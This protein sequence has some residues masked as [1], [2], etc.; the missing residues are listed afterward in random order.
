MATGK[1]SSNKK[2]IKTSNHSRS[3]KSI[4]SNSPTGIRRKLHGRDEA[5]KSLRKKGKVFLADC[6][7]EDLKKIGL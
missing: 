4:S 5:P 2:G 6:S 1:Y 7:K 3:G